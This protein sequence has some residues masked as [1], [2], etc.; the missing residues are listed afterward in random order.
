MNQS[1]VNETGLKRGPRIYRT[2]A[3]WR[4][5]IE[6]LNVTEL[7]HKEFCRQHQVTSSGLYKWR[8][9][10]AETSASSTFIEI[11]DKLRSSEGESN[12]VPPFTTDWDVELTLGQGM[13]LR[14]NTGG[15]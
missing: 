14:I 5:L 10:F 12:R 9:V 3:Q 6:K 13:V 1:N 8:K 4:T 15:S 7:T 2:Q 11:S